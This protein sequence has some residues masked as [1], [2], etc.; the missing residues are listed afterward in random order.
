M[1]SLRRFLHT[2]LVLVL[3]LAMLLPTA[4]VATAQ[5]AATIHYHRPDGN[6]DGWGL[7]VW[8]AAAQ[9]TLW[10]EPLT[11]VGEDDFGVFWV[12]PLADDG[13]LGFII[14]RGDEKDPGPDQFLNL[15]AGREAWI[16]SGMPDIY[17]QSV[18]P[19]DLPTGLPTAPEPGLTPSAVSFPGDYASILGGVDWQPA[20]PAVQ[21]SDPDGD[22]VWT[23]TVTLPGGKYEFKVAIDG[24]W[25]ENYGAGG[26]PDG[27]NIGFIVP[28]EG[29]DVIF[30]YDRTTGEINLGVNV[31]SGPIPALRTER[32][33]GV[34]ATATLRHDS[35]SDLYR[36]PFGAQPT[37]TDV[38]L[39]LRTA[40][41]DAE[42]VTLLWGS[43]S[44]GAMRF[45]P[46]QV[47]ARDDRY[48]WWQTT[49]NTG[50]ALDVLAYGFTISDGGVTVY[51]ADDE[52]HDGGLGRSYTAMPAGDLGWNIYVYD[53]DFEAP[54]WAR[55]ATIYQIFPDRFR[56]GDPSNNPTA[57]DWFYPDEC[58]GHA[59]PI[60]P[61]NSLVPDP[62]PYDPNRNPEWYGTY[63]CTF[64][65]G[66]LQGVQEKL[67]YL[68]SL[69]VTTIYFNPIFDS[70]SNH[71]Y[72]G[73]DYRQVDDNLAIVG[74]PEA[75]NDFFAQ[76]A[77]EVAE[78][79]MTLILD[80][81]PNHSSSDSPFFDRFDRH[82]TVG[83]CESEAGPYRGWYFF[84]PA[85]PAG[86]GAC[87]GDVNFRGWFNVATLPQLDTANEEVIDNWL[88]EEGIALTWLDLPGVDGWRI[89]VVPDVVNINPHFFELM[90]TAVKAAHPDALL[91]SETWRED[92]A[93]LRVL[94]DEFDT[95]MN[96]RFR[97]AV[98]GFLRD[99]NFEDNDGGV[100]ALSATEFEA[101]LR[102]MQEDYPPA[103]FATAMNLLSSHDVNRAVR[104]LDHDG[105]DF[106]ALE[107]NNGFE[108]GRARLALAAVLQFTLPGAPTIYYGD[109]VGLV[110]FGSDAGRDDPYNRQPYPWPDADGYDDLPAW[111]QQ[112]TELLAHYQRLGQLRQQHSF[113]RTGSWDTLLVD[114]AGLV[115]FGRKDASGAALIA[116]NRSATDLPVSF[117]AS[118]YLPW[119]AELRD[120]FGDATLTVGA[121][122][123]IAFDAP[124]LGFQ[125]WVTAE[126]VDFTTPFA[127]EI[128]ETA[129]GNGSVTLTIQGDDSAERYAVLRS[130][131]DGGFVE[132]AVLPGSDVPFDF[133]DTGLTNGATYFYRVAAIGYNGLRSDA[134]DAVAP[135]PHA[136]V[137]SVVV[138]APLTFQHTLSAI[139]PSQET[140]AAVFA[141]GLTD[142]VGRAPGVIM[143]AGWS[144]LDSDGAF[145]WTDGE[146]VTD[147]QG[148][149]DVYAARLLPDAVGEYA[150]KW[151]ASTTG[152]REWTESI[153]EARMTVFPNP[154]TEAPRPP[155]RL[156]EVARNA[157]LIAIG[158]RASR[159]GDLHAFRICRTDLTADE[160]GCA[161][162]VDVPKITSIFTDTTVTSGHTYV[163]TVQSVDT[164][165]N[166]SEPSPAITLTA[167]LSMVDVTW[168]VLVPAE[169]PTEDMLFIAGDNVDAFL[170]PYNPGLTP[171]T[172]VDDRHWEFT[173]TLKEGA[174]L[175]YKYTRGSWETV[176]QWGSI[177][178]FGNRQLTVVKG[179]DGTMLVEDTATDWGAEGP[180]DRRA[181]QFWRD[182]LVTAVSPA[183]GGGGPA[184]A[185]ITAE[186]SI[187]VSP[188]GGDAAQVITVTAADGRVIEGAVTLT[189]ARI[190]TFTPAASLS[191]GEYT[192]TVFNVEQTTPMV[193][194]YT[195]R[196][197]VTD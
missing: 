153:N 111:R 183:P 60:S 129:E 73:R 13:E 117:D 120:P 74:D 163:Y 72:D 33:D 17:L 106:A 189:Q 80:G 164:A 172:P 100:P 113:L 185:T 58:G 45:A 157:G 108:D 5:D 175:L 125:L 145:T 102:A 83:A 104:V 32:G 1:H 137:Q 170:A 148:G 105:I 40:A 94:G 169:T 75:S 43:V 68:Q 131:V 109:E 18:D 187:L 2:L 63:N 178:G 69:G 165:F 84:D 115:V 81:V 140:R 59:R 44:D 160:E 119:G 12:V 188:I 184:P 6:Y 52:R 7:H 118:G 65:G 25:D 29:G 9:E 143:Q 67:D 130:P 167:E 10:A 89:D 57:D 146:Y 190:A 116:V 93:R 64:F 92:E 127:P 197:I 79:G 48:E 147:N 110:G 26:A 166:I 195:W 168:R 36:V 101:A 156:D 191:A 87:A 141:P 161:V 150:V 14:H 39:R 99:G 82:E 28:D 180:D 192:A 16:V 66:D 91:I 61:W 123:N 193:A 152:G 107:P 23:L 114:D 181:I 182:P 77:A 149:G 112:D 37:N 179:D 56:D 27:P 96:Y 121:L 176:E 70:P 132:I 21:G 35:R 49:I 128:V 85:R 103:A 138:E 155:F 139:E 162:S 88:G 20:D 41:N 151:R 194:P 98:L 15:A 177:S 46:M 62:E 134:S 136:V 174:T 42:Q 11:P 196:F 144:L 19:D 173:A 158:I 50:A 97:S 4:P 30:Y 51:Y 90:R 133:T 24:A 78:R 8:G 142:V 154:D 186:F 124:A 31:A 122:G 53:P 55:N 135:T 76:F 171:M 159:G 22:G 3:A 71:K 38:T 126:D 34:I 95:T 54:A 47:V 86:T